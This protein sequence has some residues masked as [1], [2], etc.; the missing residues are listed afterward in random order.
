M[1]QVE[2]LILDKLD[3]IDARLEGMEERLNVMEERL[4][5]MEARLNV[6]EE[7][8]DAMDVRM[9]DLEAAVRN[10]DKRLTDE[11]S[12]VR[13]LIENDISRKIDIIGEGHDFLNRRVDNAVEQGARW[14]KIELGQLNLKIEV[15]KIRNQVSLA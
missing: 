3:G 6:M 7:R 2:K 11:V 5:G 9:D 15:D 12:K 14:E 8:L 10:L 13:M 4:G 1:T